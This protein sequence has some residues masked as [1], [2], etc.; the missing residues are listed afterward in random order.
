M[1]QKRKPK[2]A[3]IQF[4][5]AGVVAIVLGIGAIA[6]TYIIITNISG[7]WHRAVSDDLGWVK[8]Y[9]DFCDQPWTKRMPGTSRSGERRVP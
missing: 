1:V 5:L 3:F 6:L 9:E 4:A 8:R 2:K 7:Q